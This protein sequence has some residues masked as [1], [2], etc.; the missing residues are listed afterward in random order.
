MLKK[1]KKVGL[2]GIKKFIIEEAT[3]SEMIELI[4]LMRVRKSALDL[5]K[6][7]GKRKKVFDRVK[8][9]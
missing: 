3:E 5:E 7:A 9:K 1:G 4:E 6:V 2:K 8:N